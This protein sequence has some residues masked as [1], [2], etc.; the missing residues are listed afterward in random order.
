M[1]FFFIRAGDY[2]I[3]TFVILHL[4]CGEFVILFIYWTVDYVSFGLYVISS[5]GLL[6]QV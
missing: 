1:W 6:A 4:F 2:V 5:S 3:A